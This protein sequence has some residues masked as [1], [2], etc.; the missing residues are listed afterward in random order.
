VNSTHL[1]RYLQ[2]QAAFQT[3]CQGLSSAGLAESESPHEYDSYQVDIQ[4]GNVRGAGTKARAWVQLVGTH[5]VSDKVC[6][7]GSDDGFP[8][9]SNLTMQVHVPKE[10]GVLKRVFVERAKRSASDVGDGWFLEHVMVHGPH[11]EL[12]VFPCHSW[13]GSSDCGYINGEPT[14]L[15]ESPRTKPNNEYYVR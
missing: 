12:T 1:A 7:E 4:T 11:G 8:R 14:C 6:F 5:G 10:L 15:Q 3:T 13:F 9:G 2:R